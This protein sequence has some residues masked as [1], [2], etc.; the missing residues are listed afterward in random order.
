[1]NEVFNKSEL[2]EEIDDD[3]EFLAEMFEMLEE[4]APALLV[5]IRDGFNKGEAET[6]WQ[7][8]HTLKSMVGNFAAQPSFDA[9]YQIETMGRE[10]NLND[11]EVAIVSLE[12]EVNQL[13]IALRE[14]LSKVS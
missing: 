4:D 14:L 5:K 7:S 10:G 13:I 9:A 1:M 2:L 8:A 6:I 3:L 12:A 11:M